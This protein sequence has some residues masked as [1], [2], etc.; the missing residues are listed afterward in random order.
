LLQTFILN[1]VLLKFLT[2]CF[3]QAVASTNRSNSI[4]EQT[5]I[6]QQ[7][8]ILLSKKFEQNQHQNKSLEQYCSSDTGT[9]TSNS[10][11]HAAY[12]EKLLKKVQIPSV[13]LPVI[14]SL[15]VTQKPGH[16]SSDNKSINIGDR[17]VYLVGEKPEYGVIKKILSSYGSPVAEVAFENQITNENSVSKN[18]ANDI[19]QLFHANYGYEHLV[20]LKTLTHAG[21]FINNNECYNTSR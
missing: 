15:E 8:Q 10:L 13:S 20:P 18:S 3:S 11:D 17:V 2:Q 21:E 16:R 19:N 14:D 7:Q 5:E 1:L 12:V 9:C 4:L 6:S